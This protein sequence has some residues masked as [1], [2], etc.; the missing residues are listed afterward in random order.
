V[1]LDG[2]DQ[3]DLKL[4][5]HLIILFSLILL[6]G[7][8]NYAGIHGDNKPVDDA[9]LNTSYSTNL[10]VKLS[11]NTGRWWLIYHDQQLN[12]LID[13]ALRDAPDLQIAQSRLAASRHIAEAAGA[14]LWPQADLSGSI[15]RERL[16][17]NTFFPP[18]FGGNTYTET[19]VG[20]NFNYELDFWG[21]NRAIIASRTSEASA[22]LADVAEARLILATAVTSDYF[23][24]QY[25]LSSLK[26]FQN[27]VKQRKEMLQIIQVRG[28]HGIV[29]DIPITTARADLQSALIAVA[30]LQEQSQLTQHRLAALIGLNPFT[31]DIKV[32]PFAYNKNIY[33][34]PKVL[35]ANL[36]ARRP[37]IIAARLRMEA[38]ASQVK[39]AKAYFYPDVN[40]M[41]L[42]SY[43]SF[44]L[45]KAFDS[46]SRDS[47]YGAAVDL[48]IF[49]AGR[50]RANL[51]TQYAE[52]DAAKEQYNKTILNALKDTADR[53]AT[54]H[55]LSKQEAD[56]NSS[57]QATRKNYQL[58]DARYH[59]GINDYMSV[60]KIRGDLLNQKND[61]IQLQA[62]HLKATVAMI[63]ALGGNYNLIEG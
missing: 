12:K 15:Q 50:R 36:L 30:S 16:T 40:L 47:Y 48:P 11:Q 8:V 21:K 46:G 20:L 10:H 1:S 25:E 7:C 14:S 53:I 24:L 6:T 54:L 27:I 59:H 3:K 34:L 49:D 22:A 23:Q 38:A 28:A 32:K 13:T 31:A 33:Y 56:Q 9:M 18:P 60:L 37:D 58:T 26:L 17:E 39:V 55:S 43:Q 2:K 29:S 52:F 41:A 62:Q 45:S 51:G 5:S 57:Y 44:I 4:R 61:Q 63:K 19:N 42:W 35:P